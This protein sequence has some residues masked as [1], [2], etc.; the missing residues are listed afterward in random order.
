MGLAKRL[1]PVA[2]CPSGSY[3][4]QGACISQYE[5]GHTV[6]DT[7]VTSGQYCYGDGSAVYDSHGRKIKGATHNGTS[8]HK[9]P[10][11]KDI[12]EE[13]PHAFLCKKRRFVSMT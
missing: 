4:S 9:N 12:A 5:S 7:I 1:R 2:Q 13:C 3:Y 8:C 11:T 6:Q 10:H